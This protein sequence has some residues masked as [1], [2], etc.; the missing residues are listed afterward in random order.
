[1]PSQF[2]VKYFFDR[3]NELEILKNIHLEAK[4]GNATGIFLSGRNGIGKTELL[5]QIYYHL[6][7]NQNDAIP[8]F[9]TIKT[10]FTSIENFSKDYFCTFVIQ[11]LAFLKKDISMIDA[12]IYSLE[13]V[14]HLT[15][16]SGIQWVTDIMNNFLQV[17]KDVDPLNL[18]LFAISAPYRSY[19]LTGT[20]VIAIID[21]FHKMRKFCEINSADNNTNFWM[22]F[23]NSVKSPYTPHIFSGYQA[24][25]NK[26]FFD[27]TSFGEY[28]ELF[29]LTGLKREDSVRLFTTSCET[30]GLNSRVELSDCIDLFNGNPFYIKNYIHAARQASRIL[31]E[32]NFWLIYL[33]EITKGK[34]FMYWTSILKTYIPHFDLRKPSLIFL[35]QLYRNNSGTVLSN[36][37]DKLAVRPEE[38]EHIVS[39]L[40][41]SGTVE[42]GFSELE[43]VDDNILI[44]VIKGLYLRE[45]EKEPW[46]KIKDAIIGEKRQITKLDRTPSFNIT[47]PATTKAELVAVRTIEH[48]AGNFNIAPEIIGRLQVAL[49]DLFANAVK[50][51][52]TSSENYHLSFKLKENIFSAEISI[53]QEDFVLSDSDDRRIRAYIDDIKIEK[54]MSGTKITLF[55][56]ISKDLVSAS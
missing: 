47:I 27:D 39:L 44:D 26:M 36:L 14:A 32:D 22:L 8:F 42:T 16:E 20:P 15:R 24:E 48:V 28:L 40:H 3:E 29:N 1:M 11:S 45:I 51:V 9:Y 35:Y 6:F 37:P 30:F 23:E 34:T 33:S 2:T 25:L 21:D 54:I 41:T 53:P 52:E 17:K 5:R 38:L 7:T 50:T 55:K 12:C 46:N 49:T 18:F 19:L 56:D 10:S 13:D 43:P 31:S 4:S